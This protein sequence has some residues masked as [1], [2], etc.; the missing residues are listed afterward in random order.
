MISEYL[1]DT[2]RS[3]SQCASVIK[4]SIYQTCKDLE[5]I[6]SMLRVT[7]NFDI[8]LCAVDKK[9]VLS[10]NY[11]KCHGDGFK[12]WIDDEYHTIHLVFFLFPVERG[13]GSRQNF[14]TATTGAVY[15]YKVLEFLAGTNH[16]QQTV[17]TF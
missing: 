10:C 3:V 2:Q 1:Q 12:A 8:V 17:K 7:T 14:T 4:I 6:D 11:H 5:S 16:W 15:E 9:L 13:R